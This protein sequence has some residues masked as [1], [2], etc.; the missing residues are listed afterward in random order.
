MTKG[1]AKALEDTAQKLEK[2]LV[3]DAG[4]AV[5][6]LYKDTH[7]GLEKSLKN[8]VENDA[9]HA[10]SLRKY[11]VDDGGKVQE[12]RNGKLHALDPDDKSGIH[13]FVDPKTHKVKDPSPT[14]MQKKYHARKDKKNPGEGVKSEK[15]KDPTDLSRATE[16]ARRANG[17]YKGKN[18]AA[19]K[20]KDEDG[21]KFVLVGRS[22]YDR[23]H[24]ERSIGKPLLGGHEGD[25]KEL[26]TERAP[27]QDGPNCE[28]WVGRHFE[29]KNP[30]LKVSHGVD[31][32]NKV[33]TEDRDWGHKAYLKQLK[34]DH[35]AGDHSGTMGTKDFDEVG[36]EGRTPRVKKRARKGL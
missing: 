5:S 26:Y 35:G 19:L 29:S 2:T 30:D 18:Y 20:Y 11:F 9:E 22:D 23:S 6:K 8:H 1:A 3:E 31:Y 32:D 13:G 28:R 36:Q 4:Q 17:D 10:A 25:V 27:C 21:H 15:I 14:D 12:I 16:E 7:E 24:S 34:A 33:V